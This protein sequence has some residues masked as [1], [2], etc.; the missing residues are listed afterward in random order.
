MCTKDNFSAWPD[1]SPNQPKNLPRNKGPITL[2]PCRDLNLITFLKIVFLNRG[3]I[4]FCSVKSF[5]QVIYNIDRQS[6]C[7][8]FKK[9]R[10]KT[11][12]V[13]LNNTFALAHAKVSNIRV[14]YAGERT[15]CISNAIYF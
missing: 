11:E 3:R 6:D 10:I 14:H 8:F 9:Y 5:R 13:T 15:I 4:I 2:T 12:K 1:I 7:Y